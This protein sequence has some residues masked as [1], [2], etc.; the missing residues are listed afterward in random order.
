MHTGTIVSA[1]FGH[2][3]SLGE[4]HDL[5]DLL[6]V[7]D[8]HHHRSEQGL[9]TLRQLSPASITRIH[10]DEDAHPTVHGDLNTFKLRGK[11]FTSSM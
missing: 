8:N 6:E 7:R 11:K 1:D 5:T 9:Y 2:E 10:G 4:K 3:E